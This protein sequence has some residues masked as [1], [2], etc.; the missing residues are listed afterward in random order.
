MIPGSNL[1]CCWRICHER[2]ITA[3][4]NLCDVTYAHMIRDE[5]SSALTL[6]VFIGFPFL[7]V[8]M[9]NQMT[10]IVNLIKVSLGLNIVENNTTQ[11]NT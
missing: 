8:V 6:D 5:V 10:H 4:K 7:E 11:Q 3:E 2:A 1:L 9:C